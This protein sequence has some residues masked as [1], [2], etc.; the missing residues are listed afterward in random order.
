MRTTLTATREFAD[1]VRGG[2]ED[3]RRIRGAWRTWCT[4]ELTVRLRAAG[5]ELEQSP[6]SMDGVVLAADLA[7]EGKL[8]SKQLKQLFDICV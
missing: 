6:V 8:S 4:S 3:A 2:G 1:H 7:E 5:L